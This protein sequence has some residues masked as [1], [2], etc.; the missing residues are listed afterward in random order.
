MAINEFGTRLIDLFNRVRTSYGGPTFPREK[1]ARRLNRS[2]SPESS[3]PAGPAAAGPAVAKVGR[4]PAT[5]GHCRIR[6]HS[7]L[8]GRPGA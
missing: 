2:D 8:A 5:C 3:R 7:L 6:T 1:W 4:R